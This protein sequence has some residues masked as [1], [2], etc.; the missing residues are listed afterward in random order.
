MHP[1]SDG[2]KAT[3]DF[4]ASDSCVMNPIV[5]GFN[6]KDETS[7]KKRPPQYAALDMGWNTEGA[8]WI[9]N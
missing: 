7:P 6:R 2:W 4:K 9:K 3:D 1:N 8:F 5:Y